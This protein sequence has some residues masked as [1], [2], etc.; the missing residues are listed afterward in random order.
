MDNNS[1]DT[2]SLP[3]R[4]PGRPRRPPT[5]VTEVPDDAP[6][7]AA[8]R[9]A[10]ERGDMRPEIREESPRAAADRRAAE[11]FDHLGGDVDSSTD[12][13]YFDPSSIPDGWSYEWKRH[14]ILNAADP[15]YEVALRRMGWTPVP[16]S[17]HPEMMP[18]TGGGDTILR[19]GMIL[20]E[21]PAAV[22][23]RV[24]EIERKRARDQVRAKE[25]QLSSAPSGQFERANKGNPLAQVKKGYEAIPIPKE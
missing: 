6:Q 2:P 5:P 13:F 21:R 10:P 16:A 24:K 7:R 17:R 20:M 12:E 19:K 23:E 18:T 1:N 11:I 15:T 22:T 3:P 8:Q 9:V 4:R 14:T 25:E